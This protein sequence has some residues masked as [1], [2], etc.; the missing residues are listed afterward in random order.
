MQWPV[1]GDLDLSIGTL[2][3]AD[4]AAMRK[5]AAQNREPETTGAP[6]AGTPPKGPID[7]AIDQFKAL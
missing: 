4:D 2:G 5:S 3:P 7:R 1:F 6:A